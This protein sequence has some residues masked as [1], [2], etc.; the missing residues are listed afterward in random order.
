ME[1]RRFPRYPSHKFTGQ[2]KVSYCLDNVPHDIQNNILLRTE[3]L[4][5]GAVAAV[6]CMAALIYIL[7]PSSSF[8]TSRSSITLVSSASAEG[9]CGSVFV[10]AASTLPMSIHIPHHVCFRVAYRGG[11][12]EIT[13]RALM[14]SGSEWHADAYLW[15]RGAHDFIS[16][17]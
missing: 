2:P 13:E 10:V 3:S 9:A 8:F 17:Y 5:N 6:N 15:S 16:A 7:V 14:L 4:R 1:E 11:A 12:R